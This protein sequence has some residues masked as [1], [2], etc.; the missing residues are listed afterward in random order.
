MRLKVFILVIVLS[1]EIT[2]QKSDFAHINFQRADSIAS[3]CSKVSL[4]NMPLLV[5]QLT[6]DLSTQ[7]EQFRAIHTWVCLNI[8][9]DH[10]FSETTLKKRR[11]LQ[12]NTA[13]FSRWNAQMQSKVFK[14]LVRDKKTICSGYAYVVK[15]LANLV[16]IECKIV[17][18]YARSVRTNTE[19]I[20]FPNHSWNV[21][22][23]RGKWYF[24]DA[25][26]ASG[27]YNLNE[28][29]YVKNYNDGYFLAEP[30]LFVKN[31][32]PLAEK[33][34]LLNDDVALSTFVNGPIVYGNTYKY[35]VIPVTPKTLVTTIYTGETVVF[36]FN[37][38]DETYLQDITLV[39]SSG[40]KF[41]KIKATKVNFKNGIL[42]IKHQF[43][44]KGQYDVHAKIGED[45]ITSYT[46]KV[47]KHQKATSRNS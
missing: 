22:K 12:N 26:Q 44:K 1:F 38:L 47:E 19:K 15:A 6:Q 33:W 13:A 4:Q 41:K 10:Y 20:D 21:V 17:D 46:V 25:T 34:L 43:N 30:E 39:L 28:N 7:V 32:Y 42:E 16:D 11:Q 29:K 2:A 40:F 18:G 14:R 5:N 9:S 31:H 35:K 24:V 27:F 45:I 8:E 23:L 36:Q 3:S 37:I